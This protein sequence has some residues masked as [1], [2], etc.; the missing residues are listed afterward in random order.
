[1]STTTR[2]MKPRKPVSELVSPEWLERLGH[3]PT[4]QEV[5]QAKQT[6]LMDA[7]R[8]VV[9]RHMQRKLPLTKE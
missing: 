5:E 1:M 3:E 6:L 7:A 2:G 4:P 9:D 8:R